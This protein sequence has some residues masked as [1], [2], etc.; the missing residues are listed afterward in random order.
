MAKVR[1][2]LTR[3]TLA[4][5]SAIALGLTGVLAAS[6]AAFA[7]PAPG[8]TG[9]PEQGK[10]TVQK[11]WKDGASEPG[12]PAGEVLKGV[13]FTAT[14]VLYNNSPI[15]LT[16]AEG[17]EIAESV[18]AV[19]AK[20]T[21][22]ELPTGVT[23]GT[24]TSEVTD[25]S[26]QAIWNPMDLGVY[27]IKETNSGPNL[28]LTPADPFWVSVPMPDASVT[29]GFNYDVT[30]YPKNTPNQFTVTKQV[31]TVSGNLKDI[32]V[33]DEID[34]RITTT[35]PAAE[36]AYNSAVITDAIPS[37]LEFVEWGDVKI[38]G[39]TALTLDT[40]Y[41]V[42]DATHEITFL[43]PGLAKINAVTQATPKEEAVITVE[44]TT[45]V[46]AV[47]TTPGEFENS[48]SATVNGSTVVGKSKF[49]YSRITINKLSNDKKVTDL[50]GAEFELYDTAPDADGK[51]QGNKI[52]EGT[53]D[54]DGKI[55]WTVWVGNDTVAQKDFWLLETKPLP[56]H[57]LPAN[58]W[59]NFEGTTATAIPVKGGASGSAVGLGITNYKPEGPTLPL[60]GA[61]GTAL[62]I[63]GGLGLVA[64]AFGAHMVIRNRQKQNA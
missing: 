8:Q 19:D 47:P 29:G 38:N 12:R 35:L 41:E 44:L 32:E 51:P 31:T 23:L 7:D 20:A 53:T 4:G 37:G 21:P 10:L 46:T 6:G 27:L 57:V 16:T 2:S 24:A 42:D 18:F 33:G 61:S 45:K 54:A 52:A 60:T 50:S 43:A 62:L 9:A 30:A 14:P 48:A 56:N 25:D 28:V 11:H 63:A 49:N 22:L 59:Y 39:G 1:K 64:I 5:V 26:G 15:D 36:L 17:W 3:R 13:T 55:A 34:W 58:P 40:D